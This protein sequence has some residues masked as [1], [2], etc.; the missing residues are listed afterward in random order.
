MGTRGRGAKSGAARGRGPHFDGAGI[1][2]KP[3]MGPGFV[4]VIE[5]RKRGFYF[6]SSDQKQVLDCYFYLL[7]NN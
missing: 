1:H 6:G 3:I 5:L 7:V 2:G 4:V